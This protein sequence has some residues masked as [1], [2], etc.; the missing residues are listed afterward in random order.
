MLQKLLKKIQWILQ[1]YVTIQVCVFFRDE[2]S[3]E[4]LDMINHVVNKGNTTV[5]EWK[6]GKAPF[7][8]EEVV[9]NVNEDSE[10][11]PA[12]DGADVSKV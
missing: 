9:F 7:K 2:I 1:N 5:Y 10:D 6:H 3:G 11:I 12:E 4:C 8:V